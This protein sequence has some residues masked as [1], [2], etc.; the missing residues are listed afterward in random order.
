MDSINITSK[1]NESSLAMALGST[2]RTRAMTTAVA[3]VTAN[4]T[5]Y[6]ALRDGE[7]GEAAVDIVVNRSRDSGLLSVAGG[8]NHYEH[9]AVVIIGG[10]MRKSGLVHV[11]SMTG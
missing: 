10:L 3:P 8:R 9:T 4:V 7:G 5:G 6:K 1:E 2:S 11:G